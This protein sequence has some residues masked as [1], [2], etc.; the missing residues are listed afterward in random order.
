MFAVVDKLTWYVARSS[1]LITWALVTATV[2]WGL[3]LSSR[4][5]QRR[6]VPAWLNDLHR[7]LGT[8]SLVFTGI[9][10]GSLMMDDYVDFGVV[11]V[12]VPFTGEWRPGGVAW[13]IVGMYLLVA[14]QVTSRYMRRM[15]RR[16][17]HGV[18]MTSF[19]LFVV[20]TIHGLQTGADRNNRLVQWMWL[21]GSTLVVGLLL[22]RLLNTRA[23]GSPRTAAARAA[24]EHAGGL[25]GSGAGTTGPITAPVPVTV[26]APP[27]SAPQAPETAVQSHAVQVPASLPA[28]AM[29][30]AGAPRVG[31]ASGLPLPVVE[32]PVW[33]GSAD[34]RQAA[35]TGVPAVGMG[36]AG[37]PRSESPASVPPM[38]VGSRGVSRPVEHGTPAVS[39]PSPEAVDAPLITMTP[40]LARPTPP[41]E[42][43]PRPFAPPI[44]AAPR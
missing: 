1:G 26:P 8:L 3:A 22:F 23:V 44:I 29:A 27:L 16:V 15:S 11:N 7:F 13:G 41:A 42:E 35:A 25:A 21:T 38:A 34:A 14:I 6:G 33:I 19:P 9:H 18:H 12:L 30:G 39:P 40:G 4:L 20:S 37:M 32:D 5:I 10:V 24:A 31:S 28:M 43:M 17:W 36:A 2:I